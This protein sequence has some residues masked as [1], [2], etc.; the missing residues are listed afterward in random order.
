M[1]LEMEHLPNRT[2]PSPE[3]NVKEV[4]GYILDMLPHE[5][6]EFLDKM[7]KLLSETGRNENTFL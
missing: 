3:H 2:V 4:L 5:E 6:M 1:A 7:G